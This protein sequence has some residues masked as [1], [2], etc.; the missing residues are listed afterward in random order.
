L[1]GGALCLDFANTVEP[2]RGDG[3]RDYLGGYVDLVRWAEHAGALEGEEARRLLRVAEARASEV[4][5]TFERAVALRETIYRVFHAVA[6]GGHPED[7][8]L[9]ALTSAHLEALA[10]YRIGRTSEDFGWYPVD[11]G[12][13]GKP[14]WRVALS[15]TG[16]LTSGELGRVKACAAEEGGCA[17]L[18]HDGSKNKSRRWCSMEG[19]GSRVKVRR[20]YARKRERER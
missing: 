9:E 11:G 12:E 18:F 14:V 16:L 3:R 4:A 15:A 10:H 20:L 6:Y 8:D 19:C 7:A 5:E 1:L 17:W 13:L 2:R